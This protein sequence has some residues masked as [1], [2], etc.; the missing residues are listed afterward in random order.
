MGRKQVTNKKMPSEYPQLSFRVSIDDKK[1]LNEL[2]DKVQ[3]EINKKR[4][5]GSPFINKNDVIIQALYVGLKSIRTKGK[6]GKKE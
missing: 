6:Y 5:D 3:V 1:Q 2:I 4:E